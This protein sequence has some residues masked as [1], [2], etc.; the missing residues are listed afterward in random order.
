MPCLD[1]S[2]KRAFPLINS[3]HL[4]HVF[5]PCT[6]LV[7]GLTPHTANSWPLYYFQA[8]RI[9]FPPLWLQIFLVPW[10]TGPSRQ[11]FRRCHHIGKLFGSWLLRDKLWRTSATYDRNT[12]R[13]S[14]R[15]LWCNYSMK[16]ACC[17]FID[18]IETIS[19]FLVC[20]FGKKLKPRCIS[21]QT[22]NMP[23]KIFLYNSNENYMHFLIFIK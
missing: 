21:G 9:L 4:F 8:Q 6:S 1:A 19:V 17:F 20:A 7:H 16:N 11:L 15:C 14:W 22:F 13:V 2:S 12:K 5:L 23:P 10:V 18:S 3:E